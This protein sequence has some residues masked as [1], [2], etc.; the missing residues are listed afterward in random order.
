MTAVEDQSQ[1][2]SCTAN[3]LAGAYEYLTKKANG[4]ETDV[5]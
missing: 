2:A 1:L 3:C 5:S 4:R